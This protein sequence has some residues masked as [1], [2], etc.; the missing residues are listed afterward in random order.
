M[1]VRQTPVILG[2]HKVA[3][4]P[5]STEMDDVAAVRIALLLLQEAEESRVTGI[6]AVNLTEPPG[7]VGTRR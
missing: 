4:R 3:R 7:I 1:R 2:V 5:A 6:L